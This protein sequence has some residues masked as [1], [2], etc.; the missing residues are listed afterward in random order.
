MNIAKCRMQDLIFILCILHSVFCIAACSIPSLESQQC[1]QARDA[2]KEFYSFHFGN[3]M[4]PSSENLKLREKFLTP[5]LFDRL[6][7]VTSSKADYFTATDNFPKAFRVGSCIEASDNK[8]DMQVL[9]FWK[10]D[11]RS[12]Q[13]EVRVETVKQN[14]QWLIDSITSL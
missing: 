13:K 9:L 6:L 14:G 8:A 1:S 12:E 4:R 5:E 7:A 11:V 2:V 3:D 10:D